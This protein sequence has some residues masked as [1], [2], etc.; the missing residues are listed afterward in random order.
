MIGNIIMIESGAAPKGLKRHHP[1][2]MRT[3]LGQAGAFYH[4]QFMPKH[5]TTEGAREYNYTPRKGEQA[6]LGTKEF[7]RSYTGRKAKQKGHKRPMVWSGASEILARIRDVQATSKR[8]RIKQHARGLNRRNPKSD[9]RMNLEIRTTSAPER[10]AVRLHVLKTYTRE[11]KMIR[12]RSK[13][14][15]A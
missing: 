4:V 7:F 15:V 12:S 8:A 14:R 2:L 1:G 9:V 6:G 13:R 3:A 5:F 10:R 11:A